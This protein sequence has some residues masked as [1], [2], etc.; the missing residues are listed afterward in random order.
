MFPRIRTSHDQKNE[1]G[2]GLRLLKHHTDYHED[3]RW[4]SEWLSQYYFGGHSLGN[5]PGG[6]S[7]PCLQYAGQIFPDQRHPYGHDKIENARVIEA[8]LIPPAAGWI[9]FEAIGKLITPTPIE[10][11][12]FRYWSC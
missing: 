2:A 6:G 11:V 7:S 8:L 5:G 12:G 4:H 3:I 9:I 10:S 1:G